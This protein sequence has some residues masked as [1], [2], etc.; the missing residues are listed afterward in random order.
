MP[1]PFND[2]KIGL[3][4]PVATKLRDFC[5]ANYK[6]AALDVIREAVEEHINRRLE[7]PEMKERYE[8]ARRKRLSIREQI[9]QLI[10]TNTDNLC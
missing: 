10:P 9:M 3:G 5:A 4:E 2:R 6:A 1:K 7:N 8:A